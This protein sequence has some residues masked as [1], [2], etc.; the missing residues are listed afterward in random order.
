MKL[1]Y[2]IL[3]IIF[4]LASIF[5]AN[6]QTTAPSAFETKIN[7]FLKMYLPNFD[8]IHNSP[9]ST[10]LPNVA[11]NIKSA[12]WKKFVTLKSKATIQDS[13]GKTTNLKLRF[14]FYQFKDSTACK[15]AME[16]LLN[17]FGGDCSKIKWGVS[18]QKA[19][20]IPCIYIFNTT[21]II[22]CKV[23][24]EEKNNYWTLF[25]PSLGTTFG[26][27]P[28]KVMESDC[29]GSMTFKER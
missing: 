14:G 6:G 18:E 10:S 11:D 22:A 5:F 4:F 8:T 28:Y 19:K 12:T 7:N 25:K 23:S 17:C 9:D 3:I 21:E 20:T 13:N 27:S 29:G 16:S 15:T 1:K 26:I 24:C 2:T